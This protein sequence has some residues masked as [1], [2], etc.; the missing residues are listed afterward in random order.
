MPDDPPEQVDAILAAA[1][2]CY[3]ARGIGATGMKEVAAE[4]GIARS[5]LYRYFPGRAELL[6]A[7][8]KGEMLE[9]N[10]HI[11]RKLSRYTD[12]ADQLVEG[13][14]LA[15][16]EIPRRPLLQAVFASDEDSRA[17]RVIWSSDV[18]VS[19]GEELMEHVIEPAAGAG[20]LQDAVPPEVLVEWVYRLLLSFL[21]LPSNVLRSEAQ[22]RTTLRALLVPVLL[23]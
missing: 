14:I 16:R 23:K 18:I 22:M 21:T 19:F 6:V 2:R 3:L 11:R 17:R 10:T 13:L 8:V 5:T 12:P 9:T 1:R 20:L 7:T 4:A 15:L